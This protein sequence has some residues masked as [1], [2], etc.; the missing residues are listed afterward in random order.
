MLIPAENPD[1][2]QNNDVT[3]VNSAS[4]TTNARDAGMTNRATGDSVPT[5]GA[6][7]VGLERQPGAGGKELVQGS[8]GQSPFG[9]CEASPTPRSEAEQV[10]SLDGRAFTRNKQADLVS[11][12]PQ[13]EANDGS[14]EASCRPGLIACNSRQIDEELSRHD[15]FKRETN[16]WLNRV[17]EAARRVPPCSKCGFVHV[18]KRCDGQKVGLLEP[19]D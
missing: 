19:R 3:P 5:A 11:A 16:Q 12:N 15:G 10:S 14:K 18:V 7:F 9:A 2:P 13:P 4:A 17:A 1:G 6:E 8:R